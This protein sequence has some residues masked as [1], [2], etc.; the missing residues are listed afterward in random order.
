MQKF[1]RQSAAAQR[2]AEHRERE[3]AAPRLV[4]EVPDLTSLRLEIE[5]TNEAAAGA[6]APKYVRR[7]VIGSAP[8]L[9]LIQC[10]D[11]GCTDGGHDVTRPIME[12][13]RSHR[14]IFT[15]SDE[16]R[17]SIGP[18][19]CTRVLRFEGTAEYAARS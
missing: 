13:L 11:P 6:S 17:G 7:V 5:E 2:A 14:T 15:G 18:A 8:A 12:A 4:Q 3:D 10:G 19:S 16:C 9:F 1:G